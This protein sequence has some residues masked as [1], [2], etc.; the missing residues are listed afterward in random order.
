MNTPHNK[1]SQNTDESIIRAAFEA[2]LSGGKPVSKITVREICQIARINRSTFYAHYQDVYDLFEKVEAQMAEMCRERMMGSFH[3]GGGFRQALE[4]VFRFVQEYKEFYLLYFTDV[5]RTSH[6][7]EVMVQPYIQQVS[8]I[9]IQDMGGLEDEGSYHFAFF[10]AGMGALIS[11][12]VSGNCK[13]TP[14]QL[15]DILEREYGDGS[16]FLTWSRA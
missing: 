9:R 10:T 3:T 12:W 7:L 14:E 1:R 6:L 11:R 8:E 13:E 16:L 2:M 15:Y 5:Q 4:S